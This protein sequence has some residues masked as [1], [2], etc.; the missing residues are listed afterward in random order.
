M[1]RTKL[2]YGNRDEDIQQK[3]QEV[4][5]KYNINQEDILEIKYSEKDSTKNALIIYESRPQGGKH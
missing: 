2:V 1:K 3:V 4:I 5:R